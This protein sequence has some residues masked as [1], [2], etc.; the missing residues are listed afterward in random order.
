MD[1]D[2]GRN[3]TMHIMDSPRATVLAWLH[4]RGSSLRTTWMLIS[5]VCRIDEHIHMSASSD[6]LRTKREGFQRHLLVGDRHTPG[7]PMST[8]V[9]QTFKILSRKAALGTV[10][11]GDLFT[12]STER[13]ASGE[14]AVG[15]RS[16]VD[17]RGLTF[18]R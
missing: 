4:A 14:E 5:G 9:L 3:G 13:S 8:K 16:W 10:R 1:M 12:V 18:E 17:R 2:V 11:Q 6:G 7:R 15:G